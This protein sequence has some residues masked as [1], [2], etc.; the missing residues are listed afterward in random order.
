[1]SSGRSP[2]ESASLSH[3][4]AR[5]AGA[6]ETALVTLVEFAAD[7]PSPRVRP[8]SPRRFSLR[9]A[10]VTRCDTASR[11]TA[12]CLAPCHIRRIAEP[13]RRVSL[14]QPLD[15]ST[16]REITFC[17]LRLSADQRRKKKGT[18][19]QAEKPSVELSETAVPGSAPSPRSASRTRSGIPRRRP[20]PRNGDEDAGRG[21]T[22]NGNE[23]EASRIATNSTR[24]DKRDRFG[25]TRAAAV[26]A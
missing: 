26:R 11:N 25:E 4:S 17:A 13:N 12:P 5:L 22:A 14:R 1:M 15:L 16:A 19:E 6:K 24:G 10:H 21:R 7:P 20:T 18:E 8:R 9:P 2:A 3:R 23:T